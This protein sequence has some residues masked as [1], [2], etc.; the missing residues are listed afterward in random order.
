MTHNYVLIKTYLKKTN[1]PSQFYLL[2][3]KYVKD[4][5]TDVVLAIDNI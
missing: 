4:E 3:E 1:L 2:I 5:S